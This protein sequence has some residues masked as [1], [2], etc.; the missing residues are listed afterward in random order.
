M[1]GSQEIVSLSSPAST[2]HPMKS[3]PRLLPLLLLPALVS[4]PAGSAWSQQREALPELKSARVIERGSHH[5]KWETVQEVADPI[6][7]ETVSVTNSYVQLEIGLHYVDERCEWQESSEEIEVQPGAAVARRG[8]H[9]VRWAANLNTYGA[10]EFWTPEGE[11]IRSHVLGLAYFDPA[12]GAHVMIG[13]VQDSIGAVAGNQVIYEDAFDGVSA[14]LHYTYTKGGFVQDVIVREK[15][16]DPVLW[17]FD[18]AT[19]QVQVLTEFVTLPEPLKELAR[20]SSETLTSTNAPAVRFGAVYQADQALNFG[21][22]AMTEGRAFGVEDTAQE[23]AVPV[24]KTLQLFDGGRNILVETLDYGVMEPELETLPENSKPTA[25]LE[26]KNSELQAGGLRLAPPAPTRQWAAVEPSVNR[27]EEPLLMARA[28]LPAGRN[29]YVIDYNL[30]GTTNNLTLQSGTTYYITGLVTATNI[31]T[32]EGGTV[33]KFA[34][35]NNA[36][37]K[38]KGTIRCLTAPYRPAIFTAKDDNSVGS[39][40]SGSTGSPSGYYAVRALNID[41]NTSDLRHLHIRF[42]RQGVYYGSGSAYPHFLRHVQMIKTGE[43]VVSLSPVFYVQNALLHNV[44]TNFTTTGSG[45]VGHVEHLTA[46]VANRINGSGS[47]TLNV[48]NSLLIQITNSS[49]YSGSGNAT[50]SSASG[51]LQAVGGGE[52]YLVNTS[53]NRNV[54]VTNISHALRQD[55]LRMTTH[56]PQVSISQ[57]LTSDTILAPVVARDSDIPDRGYH[58]AALDYAVD[59]LSITNATLT[60]TNGVAIAVVGGYGLW[61]KDHADLISVGSPTNPNVITDHPAVQEQPYTWN[62][63][64][65]MYSI[66]PYRYGG[67]SAAGTVSVKFTTFCSNRSQTL[68]Y[69]HGGGNWYIQQA[70]FEHCEFYRGLFDTQGTT[71]DPINFTFNNN[72]FH[73]VAIWGWLEPRLTFKQNTFRGTDVDLAGWGSGSPFIVIQNN[74]F[75]KVTGYIDTNNLT[76]SHNG[77]TVGSY[78]PELAHASNKT[79]LVADYETGALGNFYL[80][81]SGTGL[82]TL[83]NA[84]STNANLLGLYHFTTQVNQAKET[85]TVVD[86]GYHYVAVNP[87]KFEI[88]KSTMAPLGSSTCCSWP[89]SNTTNIV[90]ADPGW[91]NGTYVTTNEYLRID[92]GSS[93]TI[94]RAGYIPRQYTSMTTD[95]TGNN[96]GAYRDY[97]IY[98]TDSTSTNPADWGSPVFVGRFNWPNGQERRDVEFNPK[99]GRYVYYYRQNAYG[100][101]GPTDPNQQHNGWPGYAGVNEIWLHQWNGL[102]SVAIDTD[103]DTLADYFED[104]NGNGTADGGETNWES[105]NSP[106]GLGAGPAVQLYT[107]L[108]N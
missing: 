50:A 107:P 45:I 53:T 46:H 74:L 42:A 17:G 96:N 88:A 32:I 77:F 2:R 36:E 73:R 19:V 101:Y 38:I 99:S 57:T 105:Y 89:A 20:V 37:L 27:D 70:V 80:P 94:A 31:T 49:T 56:P 97:K 59:T 15:L 65:F 86:I 90:T 10:I 72:L 103:G 29:G 67:S 81:G 43:G 98:V 71:S 30:S 3:S 21:S 106:N 95:W 7:G 54:G 82:A 79:N 25:S 1:N 18:P 108:R 9:Q 69:C 93:K 13:E 22:M 11:A 24:R 63:G 8:P 64:S 28:E 102:A 5:A 6:S 4:L 35:T 100:W 55:F 62:V 84:G 60:L 75:D 41:D 58:Y 34:N 47:L 104:A 44:L 85:N 40:I 76:A 78:F 52:H 91:V 61:L 39:T 83:I 14:D 92:L 51:V 68:V 16:P 48:T 12:T 33:V 26:R 87:A 23:R 66:L